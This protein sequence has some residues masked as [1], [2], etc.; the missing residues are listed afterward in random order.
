MKKTLLAIATLVL[1]AGC[2]KWRNEEPEFTFKI[3]GMNLEG[4]KAIAHLQG[5]PGTKATIGFE[6]EEALY[7]VYDN[8]EIRLPEISFTVEF[9]DSYSERDKKELKEYTH[10]SLR[11]PIL[12][13][14]G[15]YIYVYS[16]LTYEV[17]LPGI[18]DRNPHFVWAPGS[19]FLIPHCNTFVRKSDGLCL[20]VDD[21]IGGILYDPRSVIEEDSQG[22]CY[23]ASYSDVADRVQVA[24]LLDNDGGVEIKIVDVVD[25]T[26][27]HSSR[28]CLQVS[29]DI[30]YVACNAYSENYSSIIEANGGVALVAV[31]PDLTCKRTFFERD[32]L[33]GLKKYGN[34]LY[35]FAVE[36]GILTGG[37]ENTFKVYDLT[38]GGNLVASTAFVYEAIQRIVYL[39]KSIQIENDYYSDSSMVD[40]I[41]E[42]NGVF[43]CYVCGNIVQF[44]AKSGE[45]TISALDETLHGYLHDSLVYMYLGG[46]LYLV[47]YNEESKYV[48]LLKIDVKTANVEQLKKMDVPEGCYMDTSNTLALVDES[49]GR[50]RMT[51]NNIIVDVVDPEIAEAYAKA[52]A[53][54]N[55]GI[56]F[57]SYKVV[58]VVPLDESLESSGN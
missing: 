18:L 24:R 49:E 43:T 8:N 26:G 41:S 13:D 51:V 45:C 14:F 21:N 42:E 57:G 33:V 30:A 7:L 37:V 1:L 15:K 52:K 34:Q 23:I 44:D 46:G 56:D 47:H 53:E 20:T 40:V 31:S 6:Q 36:E 22:L 25:K 35:L 48:E 4:A 39:N 10:V 12:K 19:Q 28:P 58:T 5:G 50:L 11:E 55:Y 16:A 17:D 2:S 9:P 54:A 3:Q 29:D 32:G 27:M 38:S